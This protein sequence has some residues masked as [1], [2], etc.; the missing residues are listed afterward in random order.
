MTHVVINDPT[1]SQTGWVM[2]V[3]NS[4]WTA[5]KAALALKIDYDLGPNAKVS[6]KSI[7]DESRRLIEDTKGAST[8]LKEGDAEKALASA[9]ITHEAVYTTTLN[10]HAPLE[11]LNATVEIRD[12]VYNI[13]TGN[14]FQTLAMGL[15][16]AALGVKP[17]KVRLHQ[18]FLGGGFGRRLEADYLIMAALTAKAVNK[19]VKMIYSRE[20]DTEFDFTRPMTVMSVKA[21]SDGKTLTGWKHAA[22][23]SWAT[24]R[25]A[26]GFLGKDVEGDQKF[27]PF[28]INGSDHWYSIPNQ[29]VLTEMNKI[30]QSATPSGQLRSVAPAWTFWAV[31]SMIDEMAHKMGVDPLALR[32]QLLDGKGKNAGKGATGNGAKRLANV[33]QKVAAKAG[34]GKTMA[35]N[36]GIGLAA[37]SSQERASAA[38]TATAA[39]VT[40]NP[41]DGSFTVN[42]LTVG[43]DVGTVISPSGVEAQVQGATLWGL[44]LATLEEV[45]M[46]DG[47]LQASNFDTYT[48][49]ADGEHVPDLD[50]LV[51]ETGQYPVGCGEPAV[52]S[53][54][55]AIANAIFAASGARVRS[56][57]ITAEKVKAAL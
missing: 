4:Y 44:S 21:G 13:Y 42:K 40:V 54:A 2:A 45:E 50:V 49:C 32:L 20:A 7:N 16:P 14:Q 43:T 56:L 39:N 28:Q 12:G 1:G 34:Y 31:E 25:M 11:P 36:T 22:A 35:K 57:P 24:A 9:K 52:T 38:W 17:D 23:S 18:Q 10:I 46:K 37:V 55:P 26:P 53:V 33:L 47:R 5:R 29:L 8:F 41:A 19:P 48:P 51:I 15:V 27:D 30:A 3:A 6:S